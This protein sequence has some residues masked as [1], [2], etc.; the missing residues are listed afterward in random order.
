MSIFLLSRMDFR[1]DIFTA[2]NTAVLMDCR[3]KMSLWFGIG[4][5]GGDIAVDA[6]RVAKQASGIGYQIKNKGASPNIFQ[7]KT[8]VCWHLFMTI[9]LLRNP[10]VHDDLQKDAS[11]LAVSWCNQMAPVWPLKTEQ[12]EVFRTHRMVNTPWNWCWK[13]CI[14]QISPDGCCGVCYRLQHWIPLLAWRPDGWGLYTSSPLS[15]ETLSY[16]VQQTGR[17]PGNNMWF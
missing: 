11:S 16:T 4:N 5:S 14:L 13:C 17:G 12:H 2:G 7:M 9:S 8:H 15:T 1:G 6:S 10:M 3:G